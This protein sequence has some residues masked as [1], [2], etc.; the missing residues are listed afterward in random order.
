VAT[1]GGGKGHDQNAPLQS[2]D[3][4]WEPIGRCT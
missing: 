3:L 2:I 4:V 1:T